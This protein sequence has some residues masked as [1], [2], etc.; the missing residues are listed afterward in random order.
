MKKPIF[1]S[2][3]S[4]SLRKLRFLSTTLDKKIKSGQT[5]QATLI[6]LKKRIVTILNQ[7]K[8]RVRQAAIRKVM[9]PAFVLFGLMGSQV[10]QAQNFS[11][12]RV[13]PKINFDAVTLP[14]LY[15]LDNDGDLD[16]LGLTYDYQN[17]QLVIPFVENV[18]TAQEMDI[19][20]INL[21]TIRLNFIDDFTSF[22]YSPGDLDNDGDVD[23][24][25]VGY[26]ENND[27]GDIVLFYENMGDLDFPSVD[28]LSISELN[29]DLITIGN[30]NAELADFDNDGDLDLLSFGLDYQA[31]LQGEYS[32]CLVFY[33]NVGSVD[34]F[35]IIDPVLVDNFPCQPLADSEILDAGIILFDLADFDNDGDLDVLQANYDDASNST[36]E[37]YYENNGGVF[38]DPVDLGIFPDDDGVYLHTVGD[39]DGDGDID[40]LY[41]TYTGN[42]TTNYYWVENLQVTSTRDFETFNGQ[43]SLQTNLAN[44]E[45]VLNVALDKLASLDI[46]I[47]NAAGQVMY[48]D[49]RDILKE[50]VEIDIQDLAP[51]LY[52][53]NVSSDNKI[54]TLK[55]YKS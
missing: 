18:G 52:H 44:A 21:D 22:S 7:L 45:V 50:Q 4:K 36:I 10:A 24:I 48:R 2:Q 46:S 55:F 8:S 53:L 12:P 41:D 5:N 42:T 23:F 13:L 15:D 40:I 20:S 39:L 29:P 51:G 31:S 19:S 26:D 14:K 28:T 11:E 6:R 27:S 43:I 16:I 37:F 25:T 35:N 1:Y 33:E 30:I 54:E 34:S 49:T 17:S 9:G 32:G 38:S 3:N 47:F